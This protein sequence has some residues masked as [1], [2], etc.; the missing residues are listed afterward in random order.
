[1]LIGKKPQEAYFAKC[2]RTTMTQSDIENGTLIIQ[3]G[4]APVKPAE[5]MIFHIS[6]KMV[7]P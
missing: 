3:V 7:S 4:V 6:Q 5:F 2:D 1:M